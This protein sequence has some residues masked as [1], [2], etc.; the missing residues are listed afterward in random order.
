MAIFSDNITIKYQSDISVEHFLNQFSGASPYSLFRGELCLLSNSEGMFLYGVNGNGDIT[1]VMPELGDLP[2][3]DIDNPMPGQV[4]VYNSDEGGYVTPPEYEGRP[5]NKWINVPAPKPSLYANSLSELGDVSYSLFQGIPQVD[6]GRALVFNNSLKKWQTGIGVTIAELSSFRDT[7]ISTVPIQGETL[8]WNAA[9]LRWENKTFPDDLNSLSDVDIST[10]LPLDGD[11]LLYDGLQGLW[12]PGAVSGGNANVLVL[13]D[14]S[15]LPVADLTT[16][17]VSQPEGDFYWV[18][19]DN[20]NNWSKAITTGEVSFDDFKDVDLSSI[21][22]GQTLRWTFVDGQWKFVA[23]D[24]LPAAFVTDLEKDDSYSIFSL[25]TLGAERG[26]YFT[27]TN[28]TGLGMYG[29]SA[30]EGGIH[31][32]YDLRDEDRAVDSFFYGLLKFPSDLED[33]EVTGLRGVRPLTANSSIALPSLE[34]DWKVELWINVSDINQT[35]EILDYGT[36]K[37]ELENQKIKTTFTSGGVIYSELWTFPNGFEPNVS[38]RLD[39]GIDDA[40]VVKEMLYIDGVE[41]YKENGELGSE[42]SVSSVSIPVDAPDT[43]SEALPVIG[44]TFV[45][46]LAN[47][48]IRRLNP[49]YF[50]NLTK[51]TAL[52][53]PPIGMVTG[54]MVVTGDTKLLCT[55][56]YNPDKWA[57]DEEYSSFTRFG[58]NLNLFDLADVDEESFAGSSG[59]LFYDSSTQKVIKAPDSPQFSG[60]YTL[61]SA[62]DVT[63][64]DVNDD[65]IQDNMV[66]AWDSSVNKFRPTPT[67]LSFRI[68]DAEDVNAESGLTEGATLRWNQSTEEWQVGPNVNAVAGDLNS[69]TDVDI[70]T[71]FDNYTL[72][73]SEAYGVW[74]TGPNPDRGVDKLRE[75][76]DVDADEI[77]DGQILVYD[78]IEEKWS[79]APRPY[80]KN[81]DDLNDVDVSSRPPRDGQALTWDGEMWLPGS[82][83]KG[84]SSTVEGLYDVEI[85]EPREGQVLTWDGTYWANKEAHSGRGDGGDFDTSLV[86]VSFTSGVW[87]GGDFDSSLPDRPMEMIKSEV[88]TGGGDFD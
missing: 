68:N 78:I 66:L 20:T 22:D 63:L 62:E 77:E 5:L 39:W 74:M 4:L 56:G 59:Y 17:G 14:T 15:S 85:K 88:F 18:E 57:T 64:R 30:T 48:A 6:N 47:L 44:R 75:M 86:R 43:T 54:Q 25:G 19:E 70:I 9:A 1:Q 67:N 49:A 35:S 36:I 13:N 79:P 29:T 76:V 11:V 16:L 28:T 46:Y 32:S 2:S 71:P 27:S 24:Y 81:L 38:Y 60:T 41:C 73:Y 3:V 58:D 12:V 52:L 69:L 51:K 31:V 83:A 8:V 87:G 53:D 40:E 61:G 80:P 23:S 72:L 33:D 45:G 7:N 26:R 10:S 34:G 82:F 37:I 21:Q 84:G 50:I 65:Y 55:K 42:S